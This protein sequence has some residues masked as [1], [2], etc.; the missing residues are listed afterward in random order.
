ML[1]VQCRHD[2]APPGGIVDKA[3]AAQQQ[4]SLL[5][6]LARHPI[7]FGQLVLDQPRVRRQLSF[8]D[9]REDRLINLFHKPGLGSDCAHGILDLISRRENRPGISA[10]S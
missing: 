10:S 8:R 1:L 6:R 2:K 5:H 4:Q 7:S 3:V 9:L